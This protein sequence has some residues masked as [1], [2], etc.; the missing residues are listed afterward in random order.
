MRKRFTLL[1]CLIMLSVNAQQGKALYEEIQI[2]KGWNNKEIEIVYKWE[3]IFNDTATVCR[4][5]KEEVKE[6][7]AGGVRMVTWNPDINDFYT[8]NL[9]IKQIHDY[10]EYRQVDYQMRGS[11]PD[12]KWKMTGK[13][14]LVGEYPC[15]EA[16]TQI[17]FVPMKVWFSPRIPVSAG[18]KHYRG[19]PGLILYAE[20]DNG[21]IKIILKSLD[22]DYIPKAEDFE[23]KVPKKT[24][25]ID[26]NQFM[27][28]DKQNEIE[29]VEIYGND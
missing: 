12:F 1:G 21:K 25:S 13:Q 8:N 14:G 24:K 19:L 9:K 3:L 15:I 23:V 18:P 26:F 29:Q 4:Y 11:Y 27:E 17:S 6:T 20:S 16:L 10:R 5:V 28:M 2:I 7:S 22:L